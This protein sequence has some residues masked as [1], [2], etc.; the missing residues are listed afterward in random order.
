MCVKQKDVGETRRLIQELLADN[1]EFIPMAA[2][3]YY[4]VVEEALDRDNF[5]VPIM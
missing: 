1:S 2:N 4:K 3:Y 5:A